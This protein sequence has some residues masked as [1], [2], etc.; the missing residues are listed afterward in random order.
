[1][2]ILKK[3]APLAAATVMIVGF[4][5]GAVGSQSGFK[6]PTGPQAG[7]CKAAFEHA[8]G[9]DPHL[10][11]TIW[12]SSVNAKFGANWARWPAAQASAVVFAGNGQ[13]M[14]VGKPCYTLPVG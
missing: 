3:I 5:A 8:I 6:A 11:R 1:M 12:Q 2:S 10:A 13:F 7:D 4:A 14:A 9:T